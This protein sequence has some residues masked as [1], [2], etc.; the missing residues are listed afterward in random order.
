MLGRAEQI[1]KTFEHFIN[2][3]WIF[4]SAKTQNL[5]DYLEGEEKT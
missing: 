2:N 3:E 1:N 5:I 4:D